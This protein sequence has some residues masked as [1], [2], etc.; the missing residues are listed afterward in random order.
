M[1]GAS[2]LAC[3]AF[4]WSFG[5]VGKSEKYIG[6]FWLFVGVIGYFGSFGLLFVSVLSYCFLYS[7]GFTMDS[8]MYL[9]GC[10]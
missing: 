5:L 10:L 9:S 7:L 1:I 6:L 8:L 4:F 2:S 3:V